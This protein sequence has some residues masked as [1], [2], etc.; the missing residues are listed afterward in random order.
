M[1]HTHTAPGPTA[2]HETHTSSGGPAWRTAISMPGLAT[3][4]FAVAPDRGSRFRVRSEQ[5]G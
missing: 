1:A 4:S 2:A 5:L 3:I